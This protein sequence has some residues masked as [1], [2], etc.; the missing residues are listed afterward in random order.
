MAKKPDL[1]GR[2][3]ALE[4]VFNALAHPVRR[5]ILLIVHFRGGEMTA[6]DIAK[7]FGHSW[8]TTSGHLRNLVDA[9][10]LVQE[11]DGRARL[12]RLNTG[13]LSVAEEWMAWF[14]KPARAGKEEEHVR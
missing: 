14:K 12:Y 7:R 2:L 8:P 6:G 5:Q 10:L 1:K 11:K 13:K 4:V 3:E 9:G